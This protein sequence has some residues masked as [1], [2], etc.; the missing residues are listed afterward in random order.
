MLLAATLALGQLDQEQ[1]MAFLSA[2][3]TMTDER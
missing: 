2:Q 1:S 3:M